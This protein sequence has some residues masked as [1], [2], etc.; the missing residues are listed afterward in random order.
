MSDPRRRVPRSDV[1]LADPR[2][3]E[4]ER[5]LGRALVKSVVAQADHGHRRLLVGTHPTTIDVPHANQ[6]A[7]PGFRQGELAR[8]GYAKRYAKMM[9]RVPSWRGALRAFVRQR[10]LLVG[11]PRGP[12][13]TASTRFVRSSCTR[14]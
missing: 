6:P 3:A 11:L 1:L 12:G 8:N 9:P 10:G 13:V 4:A 14:P 2:L 5:M 7:H